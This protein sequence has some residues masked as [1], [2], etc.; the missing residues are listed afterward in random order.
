MVRS[1]A[2]LQNVNPGFN[3]ESVLTFGLSLPGARYPDL[4]QRESFNRLLQGRLAGLPGVESV[5]AAVPLPLDGQR[6]AGRYGPE[7]AL[8]D[9]SLYG[10]RRHIA[11]C[12]PITS[13]R[14]G[15]ACWRVVSSALPM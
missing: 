10:R 5:S 4:E 3:S 8:T 11:S 13:R 2:E 1:F 15:R 6:F 7:E 14:W 9:E 12:S